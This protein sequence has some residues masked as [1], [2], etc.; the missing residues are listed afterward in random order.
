MIQAYEKLAKTKEEATAK[1]KKY[2]DRRQK[3]VSFKP[4]DLVYVYWPESGDGKAKKLLP[5]WRG[6]FKVINRMSDVVY[7]VRN[8][9]QNIP[10]HVQRL[11]LFV[12]YKQAWPAFYKD[13][14]VT[15]HNQLN[16]VRIIN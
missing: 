2:Y 8:D 12:P 9:N 4:G 3:A 13:I 16:T 1:A 7:R 11:K 15:V 10:V 6:P 14:S 5:K